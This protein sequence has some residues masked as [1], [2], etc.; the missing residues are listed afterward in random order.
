MADTI[1]I[2]PDHELRC[3]IRRFGRA[4]DETR[5]HFP[6]LHA[7]GRYSAAAPYMEKEGI[8]AL[9]DD[10]ALDPVAR[11]ELENNYFAEADRLATLERE[12]GEPYREKLRTE[13]RIHVDAYAAAVCHTGLQ[14]YD[15]E[16]NAGPSGQEI[17]AVL[18][19]EL[20]KDTDLSGFYA[21]MRMIDAGRPVP[22]PA[23]TPP[24]PP[25]PGAAAIPYPPHS[26]RCPAGRHPRV[27]P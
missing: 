8:P 17:L 23:G 4:I 3:R 15:P 24:V 6:R 16:D 11:M 26:G 14:N 20:A 1:N 10:P 7:F 13:L 12:L 18:A 19:R 22:D 27:N 5:A 2:M 21:F 25:A 9:L